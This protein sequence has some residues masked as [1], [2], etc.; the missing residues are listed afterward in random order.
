[1]LPEGCGFESH[2]MLFFFFFFF[3]FFEVFFDFLEI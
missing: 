2:S 3:F 1:M